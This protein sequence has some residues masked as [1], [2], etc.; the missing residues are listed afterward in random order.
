MHTGCSAPGS[1]EIIPLLGQVGGK[2]GQKDSE[3]LNPFNFWVCVPSVTT[4]KRRAANGETVIHRAYMIR[5]A[6]DKPR[7]TDNAPEQ[8][9]VHSAATLRGEFEKR[10]T[11]P[12]R[13]IA[14][15][16]DSIR[17][18][19]RGMLCEPAKG[20]LRACIFALPREQIQWSMIEWSPIEQPG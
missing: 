7:R 20:S 13:S 2:P 19:R 16:P 10:Y 4:R 15:S 14:L 8:R 18:T 12:L 5:K 3:L 11:K 17:T 1:P 9:F 6:C